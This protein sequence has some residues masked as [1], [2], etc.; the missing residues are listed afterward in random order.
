[1]SLRVLTIP[2]CVAYERSRTSDSEVES[3]L[4]KLSAKVSQNNFTF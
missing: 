3:S 2:Y 1:M 4:Q